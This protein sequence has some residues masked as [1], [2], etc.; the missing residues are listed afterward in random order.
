MFLPEG[1]IRYGAVAERRRISKAAGN[2]YKKNGRLHFF[3][4]KIKS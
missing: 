1:A 4:R 2:R 3:N